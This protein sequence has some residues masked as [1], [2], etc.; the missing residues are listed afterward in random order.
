M[1]TKVVKSELSTIYYDTMAVMVDTLKHH[2]ASKK[3][4]FNCFVLK[5]DEGSD[6]FPIASKEAI[7]ESPL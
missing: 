4:A 1:T 5:R 2:A 7:V 6:E 3:R